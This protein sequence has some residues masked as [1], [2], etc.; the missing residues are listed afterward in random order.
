MMTEE[1]GKYES[2]R[3]ALF[4]TDPDAR[5]MYKAH[6]TAILNRKN[7]F[8]GKV[9]KEDPT[10]FG[11][12]LINEPRCDVN[13]IPECAD[14]L[15]NW[16]EE[17]AAHFRTQDTV[18][19]LTV[20]EEGFYGLDDPSEFANPGAAGGSRWA[21]ESGQDFYRNHQVAGI[22]YA[23]IHAWPDNWFLNDNGEFITQWIEQHAKDA[24]NRLQM[25]LLLEEVGKK[26]EPAPGT[27]TQL[28][29]I[30]D[31]VYKTVYRAVEHSM[32]EFGALQGSMLW[33][34]EFRLYDASPSTPYGVKFNDSTF[35]LVDKHVAR[36]KT[37][38]LTHPLV[39]NG[40][41]D[42][43]LSGSAF[44]AV[45]KSAVDDK[46][47]VAS[48]RG[49]NLAE[50][51]ENAPCWVGRAMALGFIRRCTNI[52]AVCKQ[53]HDA[54]ESTPALSRWDET[55]GTLLASPAS[56]YSSPKIF[57]S[58]EECCAEENGAFAFGCSFFYV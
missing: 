40:V 50:Q 39:F 1:R 57:G 47:S 43:N 12:G 5:S 20:G 42:D 7:T 37:H 53:I 51:A 26:V 31:P 16:I 25:P 36:V 9:Y 22:S 54:F 56:S 52:P 32:A 58:K 38:A 13:T 24:E 55:T 15:Q 28:R 44:T 48:C 46:K 6:V 2:T 27:S 21:A 14:L 19:L 18:H 8:T 23:A 4:Y 45:E 10:I 35:R 41:R 49:K 29:T 11:F 34:M 17:M 30:R 33:Q 3:Q